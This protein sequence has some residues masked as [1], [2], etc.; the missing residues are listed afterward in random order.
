[1][2]DID[3]SALTTELGQHTPSAAALVYRVH[4]RIKRKLL[5]LGNA[6]NNG[7]KLLLMRKGTLKTRN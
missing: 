4:L 6:E 3:Y 1:L 5:S 7:L 2:L